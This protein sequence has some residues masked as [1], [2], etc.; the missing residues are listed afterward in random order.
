M[1]AAQHWWKT[2][3]LLAELGLSLVVSV[4]FAVWGVRFGGQALIEATLQGNRA[5]VY[6]AVASICG[7]LLGFTIASASIALGYASSDRLELVRDSQHYAT[8]WRVFIAAMRALGAGTIVALVGLVLDRDGAP[9]PVL[10][11][12]CAGTTVLAVLRV[13]RCL[14]VFERVIA[15]VTAP[16]KARAGGRL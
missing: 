7:S 16:T 9:A 15:L 8:L 10:V 3:F 13:A 11:Y 6:G 1:K 4:A 5:A 14:W 2:H 12:I